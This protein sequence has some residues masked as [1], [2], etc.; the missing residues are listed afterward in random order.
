MTYSVSQQWVLGKGVGSEGREKGSNEFK[1]GRERERSS[2]WPMGCAEAWGCVPGLD[3]SST[4]QFC[5][6]WGQV[7]CFLCKLVAICSLFFQT[8][9]DMVCKVTGVLGGLILSYWVG[10]WLTGTCLFLHWC[11]LL[12]VVPPGTRTRRMFV[13]WSPHGPL[14]L[15]TN[16]QGCLVVGVWDVH[17][18]PLLSG[19]LH[20]PELYIDFI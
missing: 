14:L 1:R 16:P 7:S 18:S 10:P 13:P 8:Y 15:G 4:D 20:T 9:L 17:I 2:L 5:L 12:F 19:L 3:G 6:P 11:C